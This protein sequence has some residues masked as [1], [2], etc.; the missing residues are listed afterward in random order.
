[1]LIN[2]WI[3]FIVPLFLT[4]L[5]H[6]CLIIKYN[7]FSYL[8]QPIDQNLNWR[9]QKI[10]GTSKTWRGLITVIILNA[11][12]TS[13]LAIFFNW[14]SPITPFVFGALLGLGYALGELPNSFW[15]RRLNINS[16]KT[17]YQGFKKIFYF[18]DQAD[19]ILGALIML[20]IIYTVSLKMF[21]LLLIAGIFIHLIVDL[22]LYKYGYKK[23]IK[24]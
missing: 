20:I 12:F 2:E 23:T 7:I 8:A 11:I 14:L 13:L 3:F 5:I 19:S 21:F 17:S 18:L 6:H 16:S 24:T 9:G 22:A 4:G 1:M 15:K 10:F